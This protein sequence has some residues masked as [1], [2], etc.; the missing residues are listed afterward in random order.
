[1]SSRREHSEFSVSDIETAAT[2]G[3]VDGR[4]LR[5]ERNMAAVRSAVLDLLKDG[6]EPSLAA[7]ASRAGVATRSVYRYFGDADAAVSDAIEV[8]RTRAIEVFESEPGI[9]PSAPLAERLGMLVLR[10]LRL[11]RLV[12]PLDGSGGFEELVVALDAE[13]REAFAPELSHEDDELAM[14][15]CGQFRLRTVRSMRDVFGE[16]DQ[17]IASA[18]MRAASC[19]LAGRPTSI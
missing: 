6:E 17:A 14:L 3:P 4:V 18:M 2:I 11:D 10:R 5:R 16:S 19:V 9:S 8:R 1:M 13:V 15:L 12:E 7:I